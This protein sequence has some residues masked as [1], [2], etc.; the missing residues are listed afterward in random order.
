MQHHKRSF[1]IVL[2]SLFLCLS[3]SYANSS[4]A[5]PVPQGENFYTFSPVSAPVSGND[6]SSYKPLGF[7]SAASGG[8]M[9][10][11]TLSLPSFSGPVDVYLGAE[12]DAFAPG[13]IF[14]F[15]ADNNIIPLSSATEDIRFK[16]GTFGG[17]TYNTIL[18]NIPVSALP[19]YTWDF[20]LFVT[21]AN[22]FN[23]YAVWATELDLSQGS[24]GGGTSPSP[25]TGSTM[26]SEI[27][28]NVDFIFGITSGFSD[29]LTEAT[30]IFQD[31]DNATSVDPSI[32]STM[33][34]LFSGDPV[35]ATTITTDYGSGY[36]TTSGA[37]MGGNAQ[38]IL[39]NIQFTSEVLGADFTGTF[40]NVTKNGAA[41][42]NGQL[43]GNILMS[44]ISDDT[45][46]T[47][48]KINVNNMSI[49]GQQMS[50]AIDISG[51]MGTLN[52]FGTNGAL[53]LD[54]IKMLKTTGDITL[55]FTNFVSGAYTIN[56]GTVHITNTEGGQGTIST[57]LQTT[58]GPVA[59]NMTSTT[60]GTYVVVSTTSP[61]TAGPYTVTMDNVILDQNTCANYP[62]S[63]TISFTN[64]STGKTGVV[65]FS[66]ACNGTYGYSEQ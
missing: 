43:S 11:L 8:S 32:N 18:Q 20:M 15:T 41:F 46:N 14:I 26:Q 65:T 55:S 25:G 39:S 48:G 59:L 42:A 44:K 63:G 36:T 66:G 51:T 49:N 2:C 34:A 3:M 28:Q 47:S 4:S 12:C 24:S 6:L 56:S 21:P 5:Y 29:S 19:P 53:D 45:Y 27:K 17:N 40:N 33:N 57:D 13:E 64:T 7:G 62:T 23:S 31:Q 38:I 52:L 37:V 35:P 61:G 50:G 60:S 58:Q 16:A 9:L 54:I 22:S 30:S 10:D 1:F